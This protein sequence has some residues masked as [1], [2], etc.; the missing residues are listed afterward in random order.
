MDGDFTTFGGAAFSGIVIVE[1][2]LSTEGDGARFY[3][4]VLARDANLRA[5]EHSSGTVIHKS[6]CVL[7]R[8]SEAT[9]SAVVLRSRGWSQL[10]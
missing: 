10:F 3:G 9:G 1:G 8:V 6:S 5:D 2:T 7:T 4:A